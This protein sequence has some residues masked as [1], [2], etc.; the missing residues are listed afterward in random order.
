MKIVIGYPPN[1][2]KIKER[3]TLPDDVIF[4][5]GD[6]IYNPTDGMI[7]KPLLEHEKVHNKQQG[8]NIEGWWYKYLTDNEFRLDQE[9]EAYQRQYRVAKEIVSRD[10]LFTLLQNIAKNLSGDMYGNLISYDKAM[11][12]IKN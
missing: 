5:Y 10:Q 2:K 1:Y 3:F 11:Q 7:D 9:I 12:I 6:T 8:Y 4:T